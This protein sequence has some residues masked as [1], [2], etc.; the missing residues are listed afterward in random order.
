M[1]SEKRTGIKLDPWPRIGRMTHGWRR[2][3]SWGVKQ[4][5]S[6][7]RHVL[8]DRRLMLSNPTEKELKYA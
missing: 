8:L 2:K 1:P 6:C 4:A 7:A 5:V 3:R